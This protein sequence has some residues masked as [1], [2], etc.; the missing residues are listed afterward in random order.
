MWRW[1]LDNFL[2]R[3]TWQQL[4]TCL[5]VNKYAT[6]TCIFTCCPSAK[7]NKKTTTNSFSSWHF[8]QGRKQKKACTPHGC[9]GVYLCPQ[10]HTAS[11]SDWSQTATMDIECDILHI[12]V[13]HSHCSRICTCFS[14]STN[15]L[16]YIPL[17]LLTHTHKKT[18]CTI[19]IAPPPP[20]KYRK[21][22]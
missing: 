3:W 22:P 21:T 17:C 4:L 5:K 19:N 16:I 8:L 13:L 2:P 11:A 9:R 10:F 12:A 7:T 14:S 6:P 1:K 15:V 18:L 20:Q